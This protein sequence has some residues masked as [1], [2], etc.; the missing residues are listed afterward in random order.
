MITI[1]LLSFLAVSELNSSQLDEP[2]AETSQVQGKKETVSGKTLDELTNLLK[3]TG[4]Q[5]DGAPSVPRGSHEGVVLENASLEGVQQNQKVSLKF[6]WVVLD[7][8]TVPPGSTRDVK[9]TFSSGDSKRCTLKIAETDGGIFNPDIT[10]QRDIAKHDA[11]AEGG[12]KTEETVKTSAGEEKLLVALQQC[13]EIYDQ[14]NGQL[15]GKGYLR[16]FSSARLKR[17]TKK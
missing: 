11:D 1:I 3:K 17:V 5:E 2:R 8:V 14:A 7:T 4:W 12:L 16:S 6:R 13:V 9:F 10:K 15:L